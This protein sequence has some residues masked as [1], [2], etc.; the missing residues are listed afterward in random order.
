MFRFSGHDDL[1]LVAPQSQPA[2][3]LPVRDAAM[4]PFAKQI[5]MQP[6]ATPPDFVRSLGAATDQMVSSRLRGTRRIVY[7]SS[8]TNQHSRDG[9]CSASEAK[10]HL[11]P[12]RAMVTVMALSKASRVKISDGL[13]PSLKIDNST[14][15]CFDIFFSVS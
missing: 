10:W 1:T 9:V 11:E 12:P 4:K 6:C 2:T 7:K 3:R 8:R 5:A 14:S 15:C 13:R